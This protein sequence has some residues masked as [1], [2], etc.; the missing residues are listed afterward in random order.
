MTPPEQEQFLKELA[1][2][3]AQLQFQSSKKNKNHGQTISS[4][5]S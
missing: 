3:I 1:K 5:N 2:I 4:Q